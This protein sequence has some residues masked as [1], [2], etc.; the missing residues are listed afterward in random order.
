MR[1]EHRHWRP[2]REL[3]RTYQDYARG[4]GIFYAKHLLAGDRGM[5]GLLRS[6]ARDYVVALATGIR[7]GRLDPADPALGFLP[8]TVVGLFQGALR[9]R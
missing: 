7:R 1:V 2:P 5:L 8:G 9:F 4:A 6:D 3:R